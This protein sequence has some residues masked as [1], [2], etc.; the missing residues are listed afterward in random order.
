MG[1]GRKGFGRG[2]EGGKE[3]GIWS[4]GDGCF[5][6]LCDGLEFLHIFHP[7]LRFT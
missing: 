5:V 2:R 6:Y 4:L 7:G 3:G 1:G